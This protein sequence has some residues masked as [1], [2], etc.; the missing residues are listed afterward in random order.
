MLREDGFVWTTAR[1][2]G[3]ADDH[4]FMTTTTAN[5]ARVMQ[6][7]EFCRQV[8]WPEL[9]VQLVSVTEPVGAVL[10]RRAAARA[11]LLQKLVDAARRSVQRGLSLSWRAREVTLRGGVPARLFRISFSGELAYEIARAGAL[12]RRAG[13][14]A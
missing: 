11:T 7:L 13:A 6:H 8:L 9:D 12:R 4:Y 10:G 5:A 1:P 2:R 3:S 14:R